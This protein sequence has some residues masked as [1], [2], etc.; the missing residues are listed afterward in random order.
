MGVIVGELEVVAAPPPPDA[1]GGGGEPRAAFTAGDVA[2][3]L[4]SDDARERRRS[5]D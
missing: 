2:R 5:A 4:R 3:V 1:A